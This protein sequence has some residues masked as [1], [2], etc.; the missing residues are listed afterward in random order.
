MPEDARGLARQVY[1]R[2]R[3]EAEGLRVPV[4]LYLAERLPYLG[5]ADVAR[6]FE[7]LR[8]VQPAVR[9]MVVEY[10]VSDPVAAVLAEE[11]ARKLHQVLFQCRGYE[12]ELEG[13]ARFIE[14]GYRPV[15]PVLLP[16]HSGVVRVKGRLVGHGEH[17][18]GGRVHHYRGA[19]LCP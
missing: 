14:V 19:A 8:D 2:L 3:A 15:P 1:A 5:A 4:E 6:I 10:P 13:R 17:L 16:E 12:E 7:Y 9:L 11:P 18:S